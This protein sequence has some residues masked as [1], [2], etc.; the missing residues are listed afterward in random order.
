[1]ERG[2]GWF[3]FL[4]TALLL[5][6]FGYYLYNVA[7][8]RGWFV[9]KAKF[10]IYVASSTGLNIGDPVTIM[11]FTVGHIT[12]VHP[13]PPEAKQNV[14]VE[15]EVFNPFFRYIQTQG[16]FV[17]VNPAGFLNQRL[18]EITRGTNGYAVCVTQ[19]ITI[20]TNLDQLKSDVD[21]QPNQWQ[22][23]QEIY[24]ENSNLLY[25]AYTWLNDSNLARIA[26]L[27]LPSVS[28]YNNTERDNHFIAAWW[29]PRSHA[30][31]AF[32]TNDDTAWLPVSETP[33]VA[34]RLQAMISDVQNALPNFLALTNQLTRILDNTAQVTSNLNITVVETHPLLTNANV[35]LSRLDTNLN[36]TILQVGP[37]L[38]NANSFVVNLNTNVTA[39]LEN[40]ADISSNLDMQVQN[41][42]NMLEGISKMI[43]DYDAFVLGL[44]HHWLLRSAFKKTNT[45]SSTDAKSPSP[46][47]KTPR[48]SGSP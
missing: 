6:G 17:R 42:T 4:A 40:L 15:F 23:S 1:M 32:G 8:Q 34:D 48:Q 7:Q 41:D 46:S 44:E 22:L 16:S 5:F 31:R 2:V 9:T 19:P 12:R 37:L 38:T 33:P 21:S 3:V 30:Y 25:R 13:M 20:F 18:I 24:D 47:L 14:R 43:T 26:S 28:A 11:G 29:H 36:A 10:H 45:N 27:N 35:T 39:T